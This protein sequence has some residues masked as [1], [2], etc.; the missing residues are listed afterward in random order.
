M[1]VLLL[2]AMVLGTTA[3]DQP[4]R[5]DELSHA[6][7]RDQYGQEEC[8]AD[9]RGTVVVVMVVT[10]KRL[11]N[12]RP[13]EEELRQHFE[14]VDYLRITDVPEDSPASHEQIAEKLTERVPDGVSVLIDLDRLWATTLELDTE[15]P[16]L[17]LID[18]DGRLIEGFRGKHSPE[19]AREVVEALQVIVGGP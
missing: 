16:N 8:L 9:H 18:A 10:A 11:R 14:E 6:K 12:I 13:W 15:R 7:L 1:V 2:I 5:F 3:T 4:A 19:L 17:L